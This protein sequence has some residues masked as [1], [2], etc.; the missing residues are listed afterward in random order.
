MTEDK[1]NQ[2]LENALWK[3]A[4]ELRGTMNA[5]DFKD[6]ILSFLF[7]YYIS[8]NYEEVAKN[9][10]GPDYPEPEENYTPLEIWYEDNA[11]DVPF[12]EENIRNKLNYCIHPK[13]LWSSIYELASIQASELVQTLE[14]GFKHIEN[15]LFGNSSKGLFLEL[16]FN[17][18]KLGGKPEERNKKICT[19]ITKIGKTVP[20]FSNNK[21]LLGDAYEYLISNFAASS[22]N[23]S[24]E[25]Y[26]PQEIST[27]LSRIVTL[28]SREP[29]KGK[30]TKLRRVLDFT[31]GSGSLLLNVHKHIGARR[32]G[33]IYGQEINFITYNLA[34]MNMLLHGVK[35]GRFK[36]HNGDSLANDWCLLN[37]T[38]PKKK[39]K[40]DAIVANPPFSYKWTHTEDL[41]EDFRFKNY[42]LAPKS[43]ADFAF[44]L[45]GFNFLSDDGTMAIIL[46][47]GVLFRGGVEKRIRTKLL[48]D[49]NIDTVI[50]LPANLFFTTSIPVCVIILKKCKNTD[51]VL[52][53][54]ASEHFK[55]DRKKNYLLPEHINKIVKTYQ[56]RP[57]EVERYARN[58]KMVEI[59]KN[60]YNL[61]I[62]Q[63][64]STQ[65]E[66]EEID[67]VEVIRNLIELEK[68]IEKSR[69]EFNAFLKE[70]GLWPLP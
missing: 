3:I 58:V 18:D 43:T 27:L 56:N 39:I 13:Y 46:P 37:R 36:I 11:K 8:S 22:S 61:N 2:K 68:E 35:I 24:G 50:G 51:D 33:K 1:T 53:I 19:I 70:L 14:D 67:I 55:K 23:N 5:N 42:G 30:K 6:Y 28:D 47:H 41:K 34:R 21:D 15:E 45:H 57:E 63:Y 38:N 66:K 49:G 59:E 26:T 17:S 29:S 62:T 31:C 25:F 12:F 16:N 7:L 10:L 40:C 64:V 52:F 4:V 69:K 60:D 9:E 44:L 54:N 48:K 65:E 20:M 32:I